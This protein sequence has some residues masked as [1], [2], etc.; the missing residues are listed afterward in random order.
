M[1][2][3]PLIQESLYKSDISKLSQF[4]PVENGTHAEKGFKITP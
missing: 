1:L 2:H 3:D 4:F